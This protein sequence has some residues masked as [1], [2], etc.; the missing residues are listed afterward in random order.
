MT[1][2]DELF[3]T[4]WS[5]GELVAFHSARKLLLLAHSPEEYRK[6]GVLVAGAAGIE[7]S[8]VEELYRRNYAA[9]LSTSPSYGMNMN[10]LQHTAAYFKKC[11]SEEMRHEVL[12]VIRDFGSGAVSLEEVKALILRHARTQNLTYLASQVFLH[13]VT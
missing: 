5:L 10:A 7:R 4:G 2:L 11:P 12:D 6:L 9:A 8:E 3:R 13:P 1:E